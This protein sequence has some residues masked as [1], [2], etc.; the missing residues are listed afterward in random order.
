MLLRLKPLAVFAVLLLANWSAT[1]MAQGIDHPCAKD[2]PI[3]GQVES[4]TLLKVQLQDQDAL[5][6][7]ASLVIVD[8]KNANGAIRT[9]A[10]LHIYNLTDKPDRYGRRLGQFFLVTADNPEPFWYQGALL[11]A[12]LALFDGRGG[13]NDCTRAMLAAEKR[14]QQSRAGKWFSSALESQSDDI[15]E[16]NRLDGY[17]G[18]VRGRVISIGDRKRTLYLN[19]GRNWREDFTVIIPKSGKSA[20]KGSLSSLKNLAGKTIRV[21]GL[22]QQAGGPMI[23]VMQEAQIETEGFQNQD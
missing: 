16:L 19:F 22:L 18:I 21:R 8:A 13:Q 20:Y 14:G 15:E 12:G 1:A 3:V 10:T 2:T 7:L 4:G 17:F 6:G 23:R 11:E 5:F 9:D